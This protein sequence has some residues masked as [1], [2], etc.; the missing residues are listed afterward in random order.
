VALSYRSTSAA[1]GAAA[2]VTTI[3]PTLPT[4]WAANDLVY[5]CISI[6][7]NFST[8]TFPSGW[9]TRSDANADSTGRTILA[10]RTMVT[11]DANP[12]FSW[13]TGAGKWAWTGIAIQP[14][15]GQ[16][17]VHS[18]I[19]TDFDN[20]TATSHTSPAFA[21][22]AATGISVLM[23]GYRAGANATTA[24]NT[25]P[26]TNWTEGTTG[27]TSDTS[28]NIGGTSGTRQVASWYGYRSGQTG[29]ITP[30]AQTVTATAVAN[31][32]HVFA[33]EAAFTFLATPPRV[34][35]SA[36]VHRSVTW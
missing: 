29:T 28:T 11:G 36:A 32:Y 35:Q 16:Q 23:T 1:N 21:A 18:G 30:G 15:A 9:T 19:A 25:T 8:P 33:V 12:I 20:A 24:V 2:T 22:G 6:G 26:P 7:S 13:T 27:G 17:A 34:I 3:T 31:L 10:Y 5:F 14:A 4:G